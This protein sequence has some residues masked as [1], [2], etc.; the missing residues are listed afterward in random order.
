M[1]S[2]NEGSR[3]FLGNLPLDVRER[4]IEKFF[5]RYGRVRNIFIKNGRFGF[6][7]ST[8]KMCAHSAY[9]PRP[10]LGSTGVVLPQQCGVPRVLDLHVS[11]TCLPMPSNGGRS[12]RNRFD[13][14]ETFPTV[15]EKD[16]S[17]T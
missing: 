17:E 13:V 3:V 6:C 8:S 4:D 11:A 9:V 10:E 12:F 14:L 15:S 2:R 7:V 1:P 5:D 16:W